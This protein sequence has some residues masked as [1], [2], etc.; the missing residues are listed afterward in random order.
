MS[1]CLLLQFALGLSE[2]LTKSGEVIFRDFFTL[3]EAGDER[4][5]AA[6]EDAVEEAAAF[7][8][9]T[10]I[11]SDG[12]R[13]TEL[14]AHGFDGESTFLREAADEG[15]HGARLPVQAAFEFANDL[16]KRT[17]AAFPED[18]HDGPFGVGD[19]GRGGDIVF[20]SHGEGLQV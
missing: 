8:M 9:L 4:G 14:T 5:E 16:A 15:L 7:L 3:H 17:G 11:L 18:L 13:V 1:V 6:V 20:V 19:A 10:L 12:G 2:H